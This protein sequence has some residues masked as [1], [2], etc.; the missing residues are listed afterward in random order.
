[1]RER[2]TKLRLIIKLCGVF[3]LPFNEKVLPAAIDS[4]IWRHLPPSF[5]TERWR[6]RRRHFSIIKLYCKFQKLFSFWYFSKII[7][8]KATSWEY[9]REHNR[10]VPCSRKFCKRSSKR[11]RE[12]ERKK[13]PSALSSN[14]WNTMTMG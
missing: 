3:V 4:W 5:Q 14:E 13:I 6:R 11:E 9:H 2:K 1:M 10:A 7:I 8:F 12:S